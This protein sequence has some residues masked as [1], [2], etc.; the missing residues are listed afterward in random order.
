MNERLGNCVSMP[1]MMVLL[2][3]RFRLKMTLS[4]LPRHTFVKF[5][6][7]LGRMW[8]LEATSGGGYTRDSHYR[9]QFQFA[10]MAFQSGIYMSALTDEEVIAL[11]AQ[12]YP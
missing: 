8:N 11:I 3:R 1:M 10:E 9:E 4:I 6:D 12:F 7:E 5:I 2:G